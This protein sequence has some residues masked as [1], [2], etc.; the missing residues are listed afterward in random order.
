VLTALSTAG[1]TLGTLELTGETSIDWEDL[2][3]GPCGDVP[4]CLWVG[5]IGDN[6]ASRSDLAVLSVPEPDINGLVDFELTAAPARHSFE[7]PEG[8]QDA[9]ALVIDGEG[10][11]FVLTKRTDKTSRI[12]QIPTHDS[13][14][15]TLI[16]AIDTGPADAMAGLPTATTAADFWADAGRLIVRGYLYTFEVRLTDGKI[17]DA[18]TSDSAQVLTG[19]E[20][21]GEAIAYDPSGP[22]IWHVSEGSH[23]RLWRIPCLD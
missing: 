9:E 13:E 10:T 20:L 3:I 19:L 4:A 11:P 22:A 18:P 16:G 17:S 12:Y 5:D 2:A 15:A 23:P 21:Q 6:D 14:M 1:D 8:P 7:Y